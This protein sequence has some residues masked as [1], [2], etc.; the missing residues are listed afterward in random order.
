[1]KFPKIKPFKLRPLL[2][3]KSKTCFN[4]HVLRTYLQ[5]YVRT[6]V[7][8]YVKYCTSYYL[9]SSTV[10]YV[11]KGWYY[12]QYLSNR[13]VRTRYCT[14]RTY[15]YCNTRRYSSTYHTTTYLRYKYCSTVLVLMCSGETMTYRVKYTYVKFIFLSLRVNTGIV[16]LVLYTCTYYY[17]RELI[18]H[19][20]AT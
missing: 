14:V 8:R 16:L 17:V 11:R 3:W 4:F 13:K 19:A 2:P 9:L 15:Y 10:L 5:Y 12:V 7:V 1:M 18:R 6:T 20:I